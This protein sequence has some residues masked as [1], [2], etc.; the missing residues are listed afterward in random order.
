MEIWKILHNISNPF[1]IKVDIWTNNLTCALILSEMTDQRLD[2]YFRV[3]D[4]G[5]C[6]LKT[7]EMVLAQLIAAL[8]E[9]QVFYIF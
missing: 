3:S 9:L 4:N 5:V 7:T 2:E 6:D 8:Y 1:L